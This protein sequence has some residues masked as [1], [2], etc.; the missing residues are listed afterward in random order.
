MKIASGR[1]APTTITQTAPWR[2][3]PA[4]PWGRAASAARRRPA[5]YPASPSTP[6]AGSASQTSEALV[7]TAT[8]ASTWARQGRKGLAGLVL[9]AAGWEAWA[10][11][12]TTTPAPSRRSWDALCSREA[13]CPTQTPRSHRSRPL[14][15]HRRSPSWKT[16]QPKLPPSFWGCLLSLSLSLFRQHAVSSPRPLSRSAN[17]C[18]AHCRRL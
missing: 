1:Q 16:K 7:A 10:W 8:S 11:V 2:S 9:G 5:P 6:P 12:G 14:L 3:F 15:L 13:C 4:M 17:A 18:L